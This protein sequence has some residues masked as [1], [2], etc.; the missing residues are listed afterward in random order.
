MTQNKEYIISA[1][2]FELFANQMIVAFPLMPDPV[3]EAWS[4]RIKRV[5]DRPNTTD[6]VFKLIKK[7]CQDEIDCPLQSNGKTLAKRIIY[8]IDTIVL[9]EK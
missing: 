1:E 2:D 3:R 8:Y 5:R 6:G 4:E 9:K 7:D